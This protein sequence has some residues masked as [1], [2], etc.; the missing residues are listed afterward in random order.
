MVVPYGKILEK[1]HIDIIGS[2]ISIAAKIV[3]VAQPN[4]V[5]LG[6]SLYNI[7]SSVAQN[8]KRN[9]VYDN[10]QFLKVN[11]NELKWNY[12]SNLSGRVY[13]VYNYLK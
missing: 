7:I 12:K 1:A 13:S 11:L 2:S 4:Q 6:E 5:L 9:V 10:K 8:N 3:F